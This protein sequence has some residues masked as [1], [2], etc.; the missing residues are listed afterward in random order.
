MNVNRVA[1]VTSSV[2]VAAVVLAGLIIAGSP[3][4]QRLN[5]IDQLRVD[6]LR[7]I[8][9]VLHRYWNQHEALPEALGQLVDGRFLNELP[10]DPASGDPYE[11]ERTAPDAV[12]LCG[13]FARASAEDSPDDYWYHDAGRHCFALSFAPQKKT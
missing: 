9:T 7:L 12:R 13:V 2:M 6:D 5:R 11:Y 3:G 1:A 8:G 10:R 4:D